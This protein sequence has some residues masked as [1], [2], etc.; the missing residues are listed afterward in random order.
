MTAFEIFWIETAEMLQPSPKE[1]TTP[2]SHALRKHHAHP[3]NAGHSRPRRWRPS[4]CKL[5]YK[6]AAA[7]KSGQQA[8]GSQTPSTGLA[9]QRQY[10]GWHMHRNE[11]R[12]SHVDTARNS[13]TW[14][15]NNGCQMQAHT[16]CKSCVGE[17]KR[18]TIHT[19][20][21][22]CTRHAETGD[23]RH[24]KL[25]LCKQDTCNKVGCQGNQKARSS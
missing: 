13:V 18:G 19:N 16:H 23:A 11:T 3:A 21:E 10:R 24:P 15:T 17:G 4:C 9:L 2:S 5:L 25:L 7:S 20:T 1:H 14:A 12:P 22:L 6:A 8:A